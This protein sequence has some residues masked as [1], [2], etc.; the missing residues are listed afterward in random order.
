MTRDPEN[1]TLEPRRMV[2]KWTVRHGRLSL[3]WSVSK[4]PAPRPKHARVAMPEASPVYREA[5]E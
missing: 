2:P 1:T 3:A 5:A 4:P